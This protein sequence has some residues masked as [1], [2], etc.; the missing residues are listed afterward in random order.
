MVRQAYDMTWDILHGTT[1]PLRTCQNRV[2]FHSTFFSGNLS[3]NSPF[4]C[5]WKGLSFTFQNNYNF[6]VSS[7]RKVV[8]SNLVPR[9]SHL[10]APFA[11]S[12]E[13]LGSRLCF[14][15]CTWQ[16]LNNNNFIRYFEARKLHL[17]ALLGGNLSQKYVNFSRFRLRLLQNLKTCL[18]ILRHFLWHTQQS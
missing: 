10:T 18:K 17:P 12:R 7:S 14:R 4:G 2:Q 8:F 9:V 5:N 3:W 16:W 13:T 1:F 11:R 15:F 6:W